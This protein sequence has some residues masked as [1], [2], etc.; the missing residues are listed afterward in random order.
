MDS[1]L[2][3][4]QTGRR[5]ARDRLWARYRDDEFADRIASVGWNDVLDTMLSHRS[6]RSYLDKPLPAETLELIMAAAQS[7]PTTSNLQAWSVIAVR[8]PARKARLAA[9]AANQRHIAEAPLVLAF[10][11][12]LARLKSISR[13]RKQPGTA[14]DYVEAFI[15]AIADAAFAAQNAV[16]ALKSLGW[17]A[18]TSARCATSRP[19]WPKSLGFPTRRWSSSA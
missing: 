3:E 16:V 17:G 13:S 7:A 6:V 2:Q 19:R 4:E 14:L 8:D 15:F 1:E 10:V 11:A 18:A 9:L 12:D 5:G